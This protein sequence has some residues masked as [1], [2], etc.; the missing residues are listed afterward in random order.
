[1]MTMQLVLMIASSILY[2]LLM[3]TVDIVLFIVINGVDSKFLNI[4]VNVILEVITPALLSLSLLM[5]LLV[6]TCT[7]VVVKLV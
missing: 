3:L 2:L 5:L 7:L 6:W 4:L 1:M